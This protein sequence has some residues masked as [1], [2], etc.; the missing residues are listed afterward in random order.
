MDN[1]RRHF[2]YKAVVAGTAIGLSAS[3]ASVHA[4]NYEAIVPCSH[5]GTGYRVTWNGTDSGYGVSQCPK[6]HN[7]SRVHWGP[8]GVEKVEK[9]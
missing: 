7:G 8:K 2:F 1:Q 5:C 3:I 4:A 6:C 9:A